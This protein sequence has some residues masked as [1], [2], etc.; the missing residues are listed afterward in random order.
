MITVLNYLISA[1]CL[2][3][4]MYYAWSNTT[5]DIWETFTEYNSDILNTC[6]DWYYTIEYVFDPVARWL[7]TLA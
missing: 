5:V 3:E 1:F 2:L 7:F 6:T 4:E